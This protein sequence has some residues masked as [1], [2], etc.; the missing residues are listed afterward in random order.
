MRIKK[1][2]RFGNYLK[3]IRIRRSF[4]CGIKGLKLTQYEIKFLKKF[5]PWG[6][7]LFS[8]NIKGFSQT[9]NLTN[10]IRKIFKDKNY[11]ILIDEEGGKVSRLKSIIDNS[12]FTANYFGKLYKKD[13]KKFNIYL[14]IYV[15]Q[16]SYIL[17]S[18]G[19]NI[20][21]VPVLDLQIKG[22]HSVIGNRAYSADPFKVSSIGNEIIK[23][24]HKNKIATVIKHIPGHG[25][26]KIDSHR[27]LPIVQKS[28]KYLIK[29]DFKPF[30]KKKSIF[31]MT[32][33]IMF[34]KIDDVYSTTHSKKIIKIIRKDLGFNNILMTDDISM[35]ALKFGLSKNVKQSFIAGCN[36]ILHCN[37]NIKEMF[38]VAQNSPVINSFV[39]KKTSQYFKIIS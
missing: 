4:I 36:I 21:T 14:D 38:V 15:K 19:I 12:I 27:S 20:N 8:R 28:K 23:K 17:K 13:K 3:K 34:K 16:I 10:S 31:A 9:K 7:I 18:L 37:G 29:Y 2:I 39:I 6:I 26:A 1:N 24:F 25:R 30:K 11:P 35:K 33:H 22:A 32:A 5:K